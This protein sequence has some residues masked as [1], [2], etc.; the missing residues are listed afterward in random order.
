MKIENKIIVLT[1]ATSGIGHEVLKKLYEKNQ[2]I[3]TYRASNKK[4]KLIQQFSNVHW[5]QCDLSSPDEIGHACTEI[6]KLYPKIDILL[7]IAGTGKP[8]DVF[9]PDALLDMVYTFQVNF[10]SP[11]QLTTNLLPVLKKSKDPTIVF[12][13]SGLSLVPKFNMLSYPASKAALRHFVKTLRF[14]IMDE[15]I[16][17]LEILPPVVNTPFASF[18]N[19]KKMEPEVVADYI[20]DSIFKNK[21]ECMIGVV[22]TLHKINR[23]SPKLA[24]KIINK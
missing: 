8:K 5:V 24:L 14:Q 9:E 13:S 2:I 10:F 12:V 18:D 17:V 20:I 16:R 22:K 21:E 19:G 11:A 7:N 23:V 15:N 1:G 6:N 4:E 3:A